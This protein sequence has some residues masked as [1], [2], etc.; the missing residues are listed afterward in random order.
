MIR[1]V[2]IDDEIDSILVLQTLLEANCPEI[3][4]VGKAN[5]V[6]T[7]MEIIQ[8]LRPDLVFLDIEMKKGNA[9]DLLNK[10]QPVSFQVIFVTAFDNYAVR[11]FKYHA[12]DYLLKPVDADSL[13][14]AIDTVST[15]AG[16]KA[17][18]NKLGT[19]LE[20]LGSV[21]F[22][23]QKI[24]VPTTAGFN[25]IL[26][27]EIVH[28]QASGA[29]TAIYL[30]GRVKILATRTLGEYESTLPATRFFRIHNS[31]IINLEKIAQ[32]N[33]GRGGYVV[34]EDGASILVATRRRD[35]LL[36]RLLK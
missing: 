3:T 8:T 35:E 20:N 7:A 21:R 32:Y 31:H 23:Q 29:Y 28:L 27:D 10:M 12:V 5:G 6:E 16:E 26:A 2:L 14:L 9:F 25:F 18:G 36:R 19:L 34:M 1:A 24:A 33:R 13:R 22:S 11:A 30:S 4:V 15:N 17:L